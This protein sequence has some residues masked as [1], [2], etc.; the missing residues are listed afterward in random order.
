MWWHWKKNFLIFWHF[1][2]GSSTYKCC[3][4]EQIGNVSRNVPCICRLLSTR[5]SQSER[6]TNKIRVQAAISEGSKWYHSTQMH[7]SHWMVEAVL[8]FLLLINSFKYL[9][10]HVWGLPRLTHFISH[11]IWISDTKWNFNYAGYIDIKLPGPCLFSTGQ[12]VINMD[13]CFT[14]PSS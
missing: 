14:T 8:T 2:V 5:M 13:M 11:A 9:E 10:P 3:Q 12:E 6:F 1:I 7:G 4:G